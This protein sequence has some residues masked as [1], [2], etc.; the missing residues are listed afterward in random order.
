MAIHKLLL[1]QGL[2]LHSENWAV[3]LSF[4]DHDYLSIM[5]TCQYREADPDSSLSVT[6]LS[7]PV[8]W[9]FVSA[10]FLHCA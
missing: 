8:G 4:A 2:G 9:H 1:Y 6:S 10:P 3:Q 7:V 5:I